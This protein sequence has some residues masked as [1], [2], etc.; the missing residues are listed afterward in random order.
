MQKETRREV[1]SP[2]DSVVA[3]SQARSVS[4][5]P[6]SYTSRRR[7]WSNVSSLHG[8]GRLRRCRATGNDPE[9]NTV[10]LAEAAVHDSDTRL[11][12]ATISRQVIS[13]ASAEQVCLA[14]AAG[15]T[16]VGNNVSCRGRIVLQF[17]SEIV[18]T[19]LLIVK[20]ATATDV[21]LLRRVNDNLRPSH[22][23]GSLCGLT[24]GS[25]A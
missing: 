4:A 22:H 14:D 3:L 23:G 18:Q 2:S 9:L 24:A 20:R 1:L 10:F 25:F 16:A 11:V 6:S 13:S 5:S 15:T 7:S 17:D 12:D 21:K 19:G 8:R